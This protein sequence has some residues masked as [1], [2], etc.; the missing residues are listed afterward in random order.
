MPFTHGHTADAGKKP[1]E[2]SRCVRGEQTDMHSCY[3]K[4]LQTDFIYLFSVLILES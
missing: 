4:D 1:G 2:K 3:D